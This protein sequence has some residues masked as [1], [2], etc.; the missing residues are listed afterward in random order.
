MKFLTED[1]LRKMSTKRLLNILKMTR[2]ERSNIYA[3]AG[4]RCCEVCNEFIG[5]E[6]DWEEQVEKLA[7][8]YNKYFDLLT[9]IL[10][11]RENVK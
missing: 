2:A 8:P 5:N 3:H 7:M 11:E 1:K 4:H 10:S 9:K 6:K